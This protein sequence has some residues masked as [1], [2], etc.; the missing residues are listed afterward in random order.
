MK[1]ILQASI[2]FVA[3]IMIFVTVPTLKNIYE[4]S[5]SSRAIR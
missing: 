3:A 5:E 2:V 1:R 4:L